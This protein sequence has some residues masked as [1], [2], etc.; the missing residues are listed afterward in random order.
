MRNDDEEL[1]NPEEEKNIL[2]S[3]IRRF[4][5]MKRRREHYFFDVDALQRII[6]QTA[7]WLCII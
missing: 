3:T 2:D 5:E 7:P 6:E 1:D 4:E